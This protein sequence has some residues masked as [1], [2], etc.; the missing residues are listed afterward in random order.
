MR[1]TVAGEMASCLAICSP[2]SAAVVKPQRLRVWQAGFVLARS[3]RAVAPTLDALIAEAFDPLGDRLRRD[4]VAARHLGLTQ[5]TIHHRTH[6]LLSTFGSMHRDDD[7]TF[8]PLFMPV[9]GQSGCLARSTISEMWRFPLLA[10]M[11]L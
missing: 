9:V 4:V 1:L 2:V 6:H 3:R 10:P 11:Y 8:A 5:P 7:L